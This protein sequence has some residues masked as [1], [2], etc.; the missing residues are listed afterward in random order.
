MLL[1]AL[2]IKIPEL[3]PIFAGSKQSIVNSL[4]LI[5][6]SRGTGY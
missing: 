6:K 3:N 4:K 1:L 2:V 5:A